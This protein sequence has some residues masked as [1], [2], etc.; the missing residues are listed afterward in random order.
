VDQSIP[1]VGY[2]ANWT[3]YSPSSIFVEGELQQQDKVER[4]IK[5]TEEKITSALNWLSGFGIYNA[6]RIDLQRSA[7]IERQQRLTK[8]LEEQQ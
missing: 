7:E 1:N 2:I 4:G 6:S 5:G 8:E 3:G